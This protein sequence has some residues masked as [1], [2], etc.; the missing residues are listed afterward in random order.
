MKMPAAAPRGFTLLELLIALA[1][2]AAALALVF[3]T[4]ATLGRTEQRVQREL[5]RTQH[6]RA[7]Y[8]FLQRK[9]EGMRLLSRGEGRETVL[10]FEGNAAGALWVAPLSERG[11]A[12]GLYVIRLALDRQQGGRIDWVVEALPYDGMATQLD[13]STAIR[14]TIATHL[15]TLQWFYQDGRTGQWRQDWPASS[16]Q[17]PSRIGI[18]VADE[19]GPWPPIIVSLPRAR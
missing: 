19:E 2:T 17:Y 7:A 10:F 8:D 1:I 5:A 18:A 15:R 11:A 12:G 16:G 9:I 13:W 6:I 3:A 14:S 4:F